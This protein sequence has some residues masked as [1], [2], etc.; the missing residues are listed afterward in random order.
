[1]RILLVSFIFSPSLG[2]NFHQRGLLTKLQANGCQIH[3]FDVPSSW[4]PCPVFESHQFPSLNPAAGAIWFKLKEQA[5]IESRRIVF[6]L[7]R[8]NG[9]LSMEGAKLFQF[10][11]VSHA[12]VPALV[13]PEDLTLIATMFSKC[14]TKP[15]LYT[16]VADCLSAQRARA[17]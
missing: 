17:S 4:N 16:D 12:K 2:I 8:Q 3:T 14:P 13:S 7:R 1:M 5:E 15:F 11:T 9:H 10:A 6:D